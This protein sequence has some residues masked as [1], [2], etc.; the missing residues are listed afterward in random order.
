MDFNEVIIHV[1]L[2]LIVLLDRLQKSIRLSHHD[3]IICPVIV[4]PCDCLVLLI[5]HK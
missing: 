5:N 2:S 1:I 4:W 3:A